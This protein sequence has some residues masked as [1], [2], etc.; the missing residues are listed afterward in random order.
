MQPETAGPVCR[1]VCV[2][3]YK[4]IQPPLSNRLQRAV[5]MTSQSGT[6]TGTIHAG[7]VLEE[8]EELEI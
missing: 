2:Y 3:C 1:C 7:F 6:G 5:H 8:I 4:S